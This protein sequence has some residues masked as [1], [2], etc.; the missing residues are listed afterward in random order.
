MLPN[1]PLQAPFA[2]RWSGLA[3]TAHH[4]WIAGETQS[5][6]F[7]AGCREPATLV[8]VPRRADATPLEVPALRTAPCTTELFTR[9]GV[10]GFFAV[11][12]S[13]TA[14]EVTCP[15]RIGE[16][17]SP[18]PWVLVHYDD[19]GSPRATRM[20]GGACGARIVFSEPEADGPMLFAASEVF[21]TGPRRSWAWTI[22]PERLE[23]SEPLLL[24]RNPN[25][26]D[27]PGVELAS[28]T[29]RGRGRVLGL[30]L[31]RK[32]LVEFE[33]Q[34]GALAPR[35]SM[36]DLPSIVGESADFPAWHRRMPDG[37][38]A[39]FTAGK[40]TSGGLWWTVDRLDEGAASSVFVSHVGAP[41]DVLAA[42]PWP[43]RSWLR[44]ARARFAI[45]RTEHRAR[46]SELRWY[47]VIEEE[48]RV[49]E[50]PDTA[51]LGE[52]PPYPRLVVDEDDHLWGVMA[53]TGTVFRVA[54]P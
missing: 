34:P 28:L 44:P 7:S 46:R 24:E 51:D 49:R 10:P 37:R 31:Q 13:S 19:D 20:I 8:A 54:P 17:W 1:N 27:D 45:I 40:T 36:R 5:P 21:G 14:A 26:A 4:V 32:A 35:P 43:R 38:L 53:W 23:V 11:A 25:V 50:L 18:R 2:R 9:P 47:E 48:R 41:S 15:I 6:D 30:D 39:A 12:R 33:L 29:H 52:E 42:E 16:T 3:L 22:T